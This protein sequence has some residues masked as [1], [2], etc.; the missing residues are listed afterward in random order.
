MFF[1][2]TPKEPPKQFRPPGGRPGGRNISPL[3]HQTTGLTCQFPLSHHEKGEALGFIQSRCFSLPVVYYGGMTKLRQI[4]LSHNLAA[5]IYSCHRGRETSCRNRL[6]RQ[7]RYYASPLL[8]PG[9]IVSNARYPRRN[10]RPQQPIFRLRWPGAAPTGSPAPGMR[11]HIPKGRIPLPE[12][13]C[14]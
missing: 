13:E 4:F 1:N 10:V 11:R 12:A 6:K 8:A 2:L 7:M 5:A 3:W 14:L 9:Q